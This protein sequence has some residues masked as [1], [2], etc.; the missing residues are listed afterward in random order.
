MP[1]PLTLDRTSP[2]PLYRQVERQLRAAIET[3]RVT[4]G[5]RVPSVRELA[6]Q[7]DVG[8]LTISTAY[9][10]LA[11]DGYLTGR[12]GFGTVVSATAPDAAEAASAGRG[13]AAGPRRRPPKDG[14]IKLPPIDAPVADA[15]AP[16]RS[17]SAI[18]FDLRPGALVGAG[19]SVGP[20]LERL[21]REAWRDLADGTPDT[22]DP[23]G[24]P[25]LRATIASHLRLARGGR[26][27]AEQVVVLSGALIGVAAV[28]RLWLAGG[29]VAA[30]E[31]PGD[32]E[33]RRALELGGAAI[34]PVGTDRHGILVDELPD[35]S[36][37]LVSPTVQA[38]TGGQMPLAR[39]LRLLEWAGAA[40]AIVVEDGRLD[41]LALGAS[42]GPSLQ[43]LDEDGRVV[44]LG[45]FA[46]ILH[47]GVQVGY[48]VVPHGL[49]TAFTATVAAI[50]PGAT[51]VQQRALGR[52]LADGH[53]DRHLARVRRAIAE[54]HEAA[55]ES[56][57]RE[58]G[59]LVTAEAPP[60]G[61][62]VVA[63]IEDDDW[64]ATRVAEVAGRVGVSVVP[65]PLAG[66][67][68]RGDRHLVVD[69]GRHVPAELREAHRRG[70]AAVEAERTGVRR[71]VATTPTPRSS[72]GRGLS[73]PSTGRWPSVGRPAV[74]STAL[75]LTGRAEG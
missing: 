59:W 16:G 41:E 24:D 51:P 67:G 19:M 72:G 9:E 22:P 36:V 45:A 28:A 61:T 7:L 27:D 48:A 37:V 2:E 44:H 46:S 74:T 38:A 70:A 8:R 15:P 56:L 5:E 11:A 30:V 32:P 69:V 49:V 4:P 26:C 52:F 31:D 42:A 57:R 34:A 17:D 64:T 20:A 39:R 66:G 6:A 21:L 62:R 29:G 53:L 63:M 43:G 25:L 12:I 54:R 68:G 73:R 14:P 71:E 1:L 75:A 3:R 55:V 13:E 40:G 18:R 65:I 10:Q 35:A 47:P 33:F 58:L 23:A 60:G 50:D